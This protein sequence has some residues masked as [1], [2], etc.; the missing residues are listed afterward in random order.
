MVNMVSAKRSTTRDTGDQDQGFHPESSTSSQNLTSASRASKASKPFELSEE[1]LRQLRFYYKDTKPEFV[2]K[3]TTGSIKV[4]DKKSLILATATGHK[5]STE[6]GSIVVSIV[7]VE[8]DLQ[9]F[10]WMLDHDRRSL[11]LKYSGTWRAWLGVNRGFT[12]HTFAYPL[13]NFLRPMQ[14]L[15]REVSILSLTDTSAENYRSAVETASAPGV[16]ESETP[17]TIT[18]RTPATRRSQHEDRRRLDQGVYYDHVAV[19][20]TDTV[21]PEEAERFDTWVDNLHND[22]SGSRRPEFIQK[23]HKRQLNQVIEVVEAT[24][25]GG[26]PEPNQQTVSYVTVRSWSRVS[27][28]WTLD[29]YGGR[30][31]V[32]P[33][34]YGDGR[35]AF[36]RW[37]GMEEGFEDEP[38]AFEIDAEAVADRP[39]SLRITLPKQ[40]QSNQQN[41]QPQEA[42]SSLAKRRRNDRET[43][44]Q[45]D[46]RP[47]MIRAPKAGNSRPPS[48]QNALHRQSGQT[49]T[50][51][52]DPP[53]NSERVQSRIAVQTQPAVEFEDAASHPQQLAQTL[54]PLQ[55]L[56][57]VHAQATALPTGTKIQNESTIVSDL[58]AMPAEAFADL[59]L[60]SRKQEIRQKMTELG[61][62]MLGVYKDMLRDMNEDG[63]QQ[64]RKPYPP[65]DRE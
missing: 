21:T 59:L 57:A 15:N 51:T 44:E 39:M 10:F 7:A 52:T 28:F 24:E 55:I 47:A 13:H 20:P 61:H 6:D 4:K 19:T 35:T 31:I 62:D 32:A 54:P 22:F 45:G 50:Q 2:Q 48:E 64:D 14:R 17:S 38:I 1:R 37:K 42:P 26:Y 29:L 53:S 25:S 16:T 46:L 18:L 40:T 3:L 12:E 63:D 43:E 34:G 30:M 27:I 56:P 9:H 49:A 8:W 41:K 23:I 58:Q 36:V 5:P 65:S 33:F 60:Q 11:V